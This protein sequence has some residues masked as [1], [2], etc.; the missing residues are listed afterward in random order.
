[1]VPTNEALEGLCVI[2]G[3]SSDDENSC[4]NNPAASDNINIGDK[5]CG[6]LSADTLFDIDSFVFTTDGRDLEITLTV[7]DNSFVIQ[8]SSLF[9]VVGADPCTSTVTIASPLTSVG[10]S[11]VFTLNSVVAGTYRVT[12]SPIN[13]SADNH[14]CSNGPY[15]YE[16]LITDVTV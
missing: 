14:P 15:A 9:E 5:I 12:V 8:V 11:L 6:T 10:G 13:G 1:M 4:F 3:F 7:P 2:N 16:L